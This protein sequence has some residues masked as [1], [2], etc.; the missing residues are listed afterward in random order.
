MFG[1]G[2]ERKKVKMADEEP[3]CISFVSKDNSFDDEDQESSYAEDSSM[4]ESY[5]GEE[6]ITFWVL[7]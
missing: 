7:W 2:H 4:N 6:T 1:K 3:I 5:E